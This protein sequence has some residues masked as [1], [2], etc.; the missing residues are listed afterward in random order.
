[1]V[2][3]VGV[4]VEA[5]KGDV[6][7]MVDIMVMLGFADDARTVDLCCVARVER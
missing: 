2:E 7:A 3:G 6:A 1:V 4:G 5:G